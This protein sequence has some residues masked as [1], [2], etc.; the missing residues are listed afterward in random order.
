[1]I[2]DDFNHEL[3]SLTS[4][5]P[6][7]ITEGLEGI[8]LNIDGNILRVEGRPTFFSGGSGTYKAPLEPIANTR[9]AGVIKNAQEISEF[10]E[11]EFQ[12]N[13]N[14][15]IRHNR[16]LLSVNGNAHVNLI[17]GKG[18]SDAKV[19]SQRLFL[20]TVFEEIKKDEQK[21]EQRFGKKPLEWV[22]EVINED[23]IR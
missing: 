2:M 13:R 22:L 1:M 21:D 7:E 3:D 17:K 19:H 4:P 8:K 9:I 12:K 16:I 10:V 11:S 18:D 15:F 14:L 5:S 6:S 20:D 23:N